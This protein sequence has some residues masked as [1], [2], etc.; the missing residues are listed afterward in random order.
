MTTAKH[1]GP[2]LFRF[3]QDLGKNNDRDWF[4][5]NKRRYESEVRDPLLHFIADF[6][7]RLRKISPRYLAD[8]RP[9]GGSMIRIYRDTRFSTDK[10]PYKTMAGALFRHE[11]GRNVPAPAFLLHLEPGRSFAG[12]GVHSPD[13]QTLAKI[14]GR[15]ASDPAAWNAAVSGREFAAG[16]TLMA[17][18]LQRPP[19]GYAADHP[20]V[21]DL[22]R[23]HYCATSPFTD[24]EVCSPDFL[25]R[26]S[27]TC[28][29]ASAFME[30]LTVTL[31]L[32]W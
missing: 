28:A 25:D 20:C 5:V 13:P 26:F 14:R 16:C 4:Q 17:D 21:E 18:S 10:S 32:P 6:A 7:P 15:I 30:Y 22:K 12:I 8:P 3:L 24:R 29:A 1:F 9:A 19:K 27:R 11:R 23:K 2:E 31:D